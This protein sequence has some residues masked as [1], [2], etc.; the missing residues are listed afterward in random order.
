M[1]QLKARYIEPILANEEWRAVTAVIPARHINRFRTAT[2]PYIN[3]IRKW[4]N[5]LIPGTPEF[6]EWGWV[7]ASLW[8]ASGRD[9]AD[10]KQNQ[11]SMP[12]RAIYEEHARI[13][14][15]QFDGY[16]Q[17]R[18]APFVIIDEY[19]EH[20]QPVKEINMDKKQPAF[21]TK[22]FVFGDDIASMDETQLINAV[23]VVENEIEDLKAIKVDSVRIKAKIKELKGML[24]Q[25][26]ARL[27]GEPEAPIS[28]E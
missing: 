20:I 12:L 23:K 2:S 21:A 8:E 7:V 19:Q 22:H 15:G 27:D 3:E 14:S 13:L 17:G 25:I 9:L 24:K 4:D 11:T 16:I 1:A 6:S 10:L 18:E 26:V 5:P 28:A